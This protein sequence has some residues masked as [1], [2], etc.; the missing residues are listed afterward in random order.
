MTADLD[1]A[2]PWWRPVCHKPFVEEIGNRQACSR[3]HKVFLTKLSL[4]C[5]SYKTYRSHSRVIHI[6]CLA[7]WPIIKGKRTYKQSPINY[8][9]ES[10]VTTLNL[11]SIL[12][13]KKFHTLIYLY[14]HTSDLTLE[15]DNLCVTPDPGQHPINCSVTLD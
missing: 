10:E 13:R 2:V 7:I 8:T 3:Y 12:S 6:H 1:M 9:N 14:L 5:V 11:I 15:P 4:V